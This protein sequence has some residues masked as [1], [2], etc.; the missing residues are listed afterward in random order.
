LDAH[1]AVAKSLSI[2]ILLKKCPI[3]SFTNFF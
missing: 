2:P 1:V 3:K